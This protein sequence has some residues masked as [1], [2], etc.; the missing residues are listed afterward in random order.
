MSLSQH[1]RETTPLLRRGYNDDELILKTEE[2]LTREMFWEELR[3]LPR[4]AWP[5]LGAQ[6]LE[7]S[8]IAI[9]LISIGHL[10]TTAL[11]AVSLGTMTANVTGVS[12]LQGLASGL[13]TVLPAA[14]TSPQ[15]HLVGLWTQRMGIVVAFNYYAGL[16]QPIFVVWHN[17]ETI[18]VALRQDQEVSRMAALYLR[19]LSLV[20]GP[21]PIRLGFIGAPIATVA[22]YHLISIASFIYGR[23]LVPKTAWHP[24]SRKMF[25]DLG[26]LTSLGLSGV[27]QVASGWWA[28]ECVALATSYLGPTALACQS[29][30]ISASG[31][32][33]QIFSSNANAATIRVGNLLGEENVISAGAASSAGMVV[34]LLSA[35]VTSLGLLLAR[36][37]WPRL[38]TDDPAVVALVSSVIPVIALY[39]FPTALAQM[40]TGHLRIT[41]IPIG[42]WLAFSCDFGLSGLWIGLTIGLI[43]SSLG[44]IIL[45]LRT[46]WRKEVLKVAER[47]SREERRQKAAKLV[48]EEN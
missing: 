36:H 14:F 27:A 21:E 10:S 26:I 31:V 39:Q 12:V 5:V 1:A 2:K 8:M 17:A 28:W 34:A 42:I 15:P 47:N 7:Y 30:L 19:W 44:L 40:G 6:W 35:A 45:W 3:T 33:F 43:L 16:A 48:D 4:Y 22:S 9:N 46:D 24:L 37:T 41:R 11:A 18:F 23:Y 13:D 38:Y 20:W 29:I 32:T 25:Y